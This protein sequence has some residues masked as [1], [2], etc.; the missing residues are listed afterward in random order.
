MV[1][2]LK[3][4]LWLAFVLASMVLAILFLIVLAGANPLQ[5]LRGL[6]DGAFGDRYAVAETF[7]QAVP[8]A[9]IALGVAPALRAGIFPVGSEGQLAIGAVAATAGAADRPRGARE[10]RACDRLPCRH[11]RRH[12]L[13]VYSGA[14]A[15]AFAG[16]RNTLDAAD[17]LSGRQSRT[18]APP[19]GSRHRTKRSQRHEATGCPSKL[20]CQSWSRARACIG[21]FLRF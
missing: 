11:F 3:Q 15:G 21:A 7:V 8:I 19:H 2:G 9:I 16:Q 14:V 1:G 20:W 12:R 17:E 4:G 6:F 10:R 18:M 13:G 5:A